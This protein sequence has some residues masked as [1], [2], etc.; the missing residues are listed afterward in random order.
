MFLILF[1]KKFNSS[2]ALRQHV[3]KMHGALQPEVGGKP[4]MENVMQS[5]KF[6]KNLMG[7]V[8]IR[9]IFYDNNCLK[10]VSNVF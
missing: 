5:R 4:S 7:M 10:H 8:H 2:N 1:K 9:G 3:D 6:Y